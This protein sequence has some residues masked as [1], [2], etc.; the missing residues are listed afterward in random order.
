[1]ND[2]TAAPAATPET[3]QGAPGN[4][5]LSAS[6]SAPASPTGVAAPAAGDPALSAAVEPPVEKPYW[7]EDWYDKVSGKDDAKSKWTRRF[8]S[9][10]TLINTAYDLNNRLKTG[11]LRATLPEN[12]SEAEVAAFRKSW[13]IPEKADGYGIE[14]PKIEGHEWSDSDKADLS[15]FL[16]K[17]HEHHAPPNVVKAM[18]DGWSEMQSKARGQLLEAAMETTVQR[19]TELRTEFGKEFDRN[20]KLANADMTSIIGAEGAKELASLT[21]ADGTR[22]GDYPVFVRYAVEAARRGADDSTLA[23]PDIN[24]GSGAGSL[25]DQIRQ[26]HDLAY[27]DP[28]AWAAP[29][30]Q[31]KIDRLVKAQANQEARGAPPQ[32]APSEYRAA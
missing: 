16:G 28:K 20:V 11:A 23:V 27:N 18:I 29:E 24:T 32:R 15:A 1:M 5:A 6:G 30:H 17:M 4:G 13:G 12:A 14:L 19:R 10:E 22:L 25:A 7:P 26:A 2:G 21:L 3:A 8:S 9:P 31:A